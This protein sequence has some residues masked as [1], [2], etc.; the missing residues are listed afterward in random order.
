[1][2]KVYEIR[3][4]RRVEREDTMDLEIA[5]TSEAEAIAEAKRQVNESDEYRGWTDIDKNEEG[6]Y[7]DYECNGTIDDEENDE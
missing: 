4:T 6:A 1:M 7:D 2:I 5:A 3:V